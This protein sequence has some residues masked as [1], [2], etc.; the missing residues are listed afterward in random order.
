[1]GLGL[2][3]ALP[4]SEKPAKAAAQAAFRRMEPKP[5]A[6][7]VEGQVMPD[8]VQRP[9]FASFQGFPIER[10][11]PHHGKG[12]KDEPASTFQSQE[13]VPGFEIGPRP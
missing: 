6:D 8:T 5:D 12:G 3:N 4:G 1:M 10:E 2:G 13:Q 7:V 11:R 9:P